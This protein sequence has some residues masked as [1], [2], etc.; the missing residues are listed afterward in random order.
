MDKNLLALIN[1]CENKIDKLLKIKIDDVF[2]NELD[3]FDNYFNQ[4]KQVLNHK[5]ASL[6]KKE[7]DNLQLQMN[8]LKEKIENTMKYTMIE[9]KN[10]EKKKKLIGYGSNAVSEAIKF[11][12]RL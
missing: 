8:R 6:Y 2:M 10:T 1:Q 4:L 11:D 5:N 12:K 3:I 7:L 9:I